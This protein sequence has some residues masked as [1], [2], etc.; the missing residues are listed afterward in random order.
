MNKNENELIKKLND[1]IKQIKTNII[2]N[3]NNSFFEITKNQEPLDANKIE[4][5][6]DSILINIGTE[7][8]KLFI[9][10]NIDKKEYKIKSKNSI[11]LN[12]F[13]SKDIQE[14]NK[15]ITRIFQN[16]A[17]NYIKDDEEVENENIAKFLKKVGEIS[18]ISYNQGKKLY[19]IMKNKYLKNFEKKFSSWIKNLEEKKGNPYE[20]FL[21]NV[22]LLKNNEDKKEEKF[23]LKLF[24][25]LSKMYFHCNISYPLVEI[26]F[27]KE[28]NFNSDNM[29]DFINRGRDRKVNFVILPSLFSNGNFLQNGKSWVFT[30]S[31]DT[32]KFKDS[33]NESL[34]NFIEPDNLILKNIKNNLPIKV[35]C[36]SKNDS[37]YIIVKTKFEIP[38]NIEY[39]FIFY[40][41][42]ECNNKYMRIRTKKKNFKTKNCCIIKKFK[43]KLESK[44]IISFLNITNN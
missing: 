32:F 22:S 35:Y 42:N 3:I 25:D 30:F 29:I 13:T 24:Y 43:M 9:N 17:F 28:K 11:K 6:K 40:L 4:K 44:T 31:K 23:L 15:E 20:N 37:T 27:K 21:N 26:S 10:E 8:D 33:I 19:K 16:E 5:W 14:E 7:I 36:K 12:N 1:L 38:K 39:E 2:N 41:K 34:N 18:R